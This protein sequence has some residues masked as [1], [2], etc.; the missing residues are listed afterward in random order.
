MAKG[1]PNKMAGAGE[2]E[3]VDSIDRIGWAEWQS[4]LKAVLQ[5]KIIMLTAAYRKE[6]M[7]YQEELLGN[8][9]CLESVDKAT[10]NP[11]VYRKLLEECK[12]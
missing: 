10:C 9:E 6:K 12:N 11:K 3:G 2:T 5:G 1:T 7:Q 8:I 4:E